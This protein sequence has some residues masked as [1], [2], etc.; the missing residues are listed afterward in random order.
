MP[1]KTGIEVVTALKRFI[2]FETTDELQI[3]EPKF[4]IVTS[5][6]TNS[7][8]KHIESNGVSDCYEKP[9]RIEQLTEILEN[10]KW[11]SWFKFIR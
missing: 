5:Y 8:R 1:R 6:V 11:I 4:V 2:E 7:F 9:L 10:A 3:L